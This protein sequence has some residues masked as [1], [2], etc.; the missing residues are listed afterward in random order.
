MSR[1]GDIAL[2]IAEN[3]E[4]ITS[5]QISFEEAMNYILETGEASASKVIEALR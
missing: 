1:V 4:Q 2:E 3:V 5:G